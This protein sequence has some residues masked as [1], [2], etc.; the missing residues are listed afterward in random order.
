MKLLNPMMSTAAK[1]TTSGMTI[2]NWHGINILKRKATP[3]RRFRST[4]PANR[5]RVGYLSR[6][7]GYLPASDRELWR[8][9]AAGHPREDGFGGKFLATGI[10]AFVELNVRAMMSQ[11]LLAEIATPPIADLNIGMATLVAI[12]GV[13]SGST[14]LNFTTLG[15]GIAGD[16]IEVGVAG[17]FTSPGVFDG[18]QSYSVDA[19]VAGNL[20]TSVHTG[21]VAGGW[22]WWRVRYVKADGQASSYLK[23]QRKAKV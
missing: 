12:D 8:I 10:N 6:A 3:V 2:S 7:W 4:Q 17:P 21:L 20:L 16:K 22:Y 11:S 23:V 14:T 9:W 13:G 18:G 15:T 5:A 1:G 19:Y